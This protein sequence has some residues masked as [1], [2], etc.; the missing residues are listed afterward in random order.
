M[1]G[2]EQAHGNDND[3]KIEKGYNGPGENHSAGQVSGGVFYF[4]SDAC[5]FSESAETYED[6]A[7]RGKD[8]EKGGWFGGFISLQVYAL[9]AEDDEQGENHKQDSHKQNFES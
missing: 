3:G 8:G 6:Q 2:V 4:F 5:Y 1:G 7:G 9:E